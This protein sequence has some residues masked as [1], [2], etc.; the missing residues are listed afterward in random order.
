MDATFLSNHAARP[1]RIG[2]RG[3]NDMNAHDRAELEQIKLRQEQLQRSVSALNL[4]IER[5]SVRLNTAPQPVPEFKPLEIAPLP[6]VEDPQ[7]EKAAFTPAAAPP[8]LPPII[9]AVYQETILPPPLPES[10]VIAAA[11]TEQPEPTKPRESFEM[12]LGTYWLVRIGIVMLLTGLVF[13]AN[14]AYKNYIGKLQPSGKVALLYTAAAAL[15]G[16]GGW[17]QRKRVT[18][19]LRNYGQVLFA[20]GMALVYFTTYAAHHFRTLQ[21]IT[22]PKLDGVLLF[23]WSA[24]VVWLADRKKSEVI[25]LF[26]VGLSYYTSAITEVGLFTLY[27]NLVLTAAAVFFLIRNRWTTLSF[28]SVVATYVG[29]AFWR[30]HPVGWTWDVRPGELSELK[31]A[32]IFLGCYWLFFTAA[33]F[34]SRGSSLKNVNR[35]LFASFNNGAFFGLVLLS[36]RHVD[37]GHFWIFSLS[38]GAVLLGAALLARKFIANE[39][40]I[41]NTYL[42]QGLTLFTVGL[43]AKFTGPNLAL[44]LAAESVILIFLGHQHRNWFLRGGAYITAALS[45]GWIAVTMT[46][47]W[48][49]LFLGGVV[50]GAL[51]L[52]AWWERRNDKESA[53]IPLRPGTSFFVA[54]AMLVVGLVAWHGVL[55]Q[56]RIV[57]WIVEAIAFTILFRPLRIPELPILSQLLAVTALAYWFLE[58]VF[59]G[60]PVAWF[61]PATFV[62][63]AIALNIAGHMQKNAVVRAS[64]CL[65]A[66]AGAIWNLVQ[67]T[68]ARL[69]AWLGIAISL[70]FVWQVWWELR[71]DTERGNAP[72]RPLTGYFAALAIAAIGIITWRLVPTTWLAIAWMMEALVFTGLFYAIRSPELP[73]FGQALALTAQGYWFFEFALQKNKPHWIVPASLV[74]GT[75]ALSHWWQRQ[76]R[77]TLHADGRNVLQIVYALALVAMILFWSKPSLAPAAWLTFLCLL[78]GGITI[79]GVFTRAWALAACAQ[80]FLLISSMELFLLFIARESRWDIALVPIATWLVLGIATTAWLSRHDTRENIRRPLLQVSRFYRVVAVAL[81]VW[82]VFAYVPVPHQFWTFCAVGLSVLALAGFLKSREA[83]AYAAAFLAIGM[84]HWFFQA[85][86]NQPVIKLPNLLAILALLAA[87][88]VTAKM[89]QRLNVTPAINSSVIV[90]GG[91]ALWLYVS[92]WVVTAQGTHL[93]LTV[94]WAGLAALLLAAGFILRDRMHRWMGLGIIACA[95]IRVFAS[96]VWKLEQIYRIL[97]FMA[98]GVVLIALGF[99]YSKYQDKIR[100][101]L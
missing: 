47:R 23:A 92:R 75:L 43:I 36:M 35:A 98:L 34:F 27:S 25:A 76:K 6:L 64:A 24:I 97:S 49:D 100:Q 87:Q 69:D 32:N 68:N 42:V 9:Q 21:I 38:F 58:F 41:K 33:V 56:W 73:L 70:G 71:H 28:I 86:S 29:F 67:M 84:G 20:G 62:I 18:D 63:G 46:D 11:T 80:I 30:F 90:I 95:I 79:Y 17:L 2:W 16:A 55:E 89:P 37:H 60:T 57:V 72:I 53:D 99:V 78:A 54:L 13:V 5:L 45:A 85:V 39:P 1:V 40:I 19:T 66:F 93:W 65:T 31:Q 59:P 83:A 14:Y 77:L 48:L 52:N 26:A 81:S 91:L 96:D 12:K 101:W 10:E 61:V 22:S 82:W 15:L 51:L 3:L 74:A 50:A 4:E 8:P 94:S 7:P 44:I 88:Q